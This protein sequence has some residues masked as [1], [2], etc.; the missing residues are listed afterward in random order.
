MVLN[1]KRIC[2]TDDTGDLETC[3]GVV[4]KPFRYQVAGHTAFCMLPNGHLLK[5]CD[6]RE[7]YFYQLMPEALIPISPACC[8]TIQGDWSEFSSKPC[9]LCLEECEEN[10][11]IPRATQSPTTQKKR[12]MSRNFLV[13][14]DLT[15]DFVRPCVL[16]LKLGTRQ[17]GDGA[18]AAK[19]ASQIEKCFK[20]TSAR[21]GIRLCGMYLSLPSG[22]ILTKDKYAGRLL[23]DEML[24]EDIRRF[25]S[26]SADSIS[27]VLEKVQKITKT[28]QSMDGI[29]LFGSSILVVVEGDT[30]RSPKAEVRIVDF[31]N[32]TFPGFLEDQLYTGPDEGSLKGLSVL[33][34][35][36]KSC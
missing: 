17:H 7:L 1:V 24:T 30:S 21:M 32:A 19:A 12:K 16:D 20:T 22:D 11:V 27:I 2:S 4:V 31:A 26:S 35:I 25:F 5:P 36:L 9:T 10:V 6:E 13:L 3:G 28:L 33:E 29:R 15:R 14:N 34:G 18:S 23:T 8:S